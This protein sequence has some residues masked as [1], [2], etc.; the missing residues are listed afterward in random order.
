MWTDLLTSATGQKA[1]N[2]KEESVRQ[3][4]DRAAAGNAYSQLNPQEL[5]QSNDSS[6]VPWGSFNMRHIVERG[7]A[8]EQIATQQ[9]S[10]DSSVYFPQA[11]TQGPPTRTGYQAT[12]YDRVTDASSYL[13]GYQSTR[14]IQPKPSGQDG[15][16]NADIG[17]YQSSRGRRDGS[18][19]Q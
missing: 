3:S 9:R 5:E 13:Q 1:R 15:S 11:S 8:Q 2:E 19:N 10:S 16:Y 12:D 4:H 6:G 7:Q 14:T 18:S 17:S